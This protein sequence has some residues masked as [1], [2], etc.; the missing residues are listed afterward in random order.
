MTTNHNIYELTFPIR[1]KVKRN[2]RWDR[3]IKHRLYH[4]THRHFREVCLTGLVVTTL[5][6]SLMVPHEKARGSVEEISV[7]DDLMPGESRVGGDDPMVDRTKLGD[8]TM[9]IDLHYLRRNG[10]PSRIGAPYGA[11]VGIRMNKDRPT[12][13]P[14]ETTVNWAK[15]LDHL[16]QMK[17]ARSSVSGATQTWAHRVTEHYAHEERD[18]KS[19]GKF[20]KEVDGIAKTTHA[21]IDYD[22]ICNTLHINQCQDYKDTMSR[23]HGQNIVAYSLSEVMPSHNGAEN[24]IMLDTILRNAGE[25]YLDS[26]PSLGD[27]LLSKGAY[28]FTSFAVRRDESGMLGG[29]TFVDGFAGKHLPGSVIHLSTRDAHKAAFEFVA[30]N[31][32]NIFRGMDAQDAN[33]LAHVCTMDGITEIIATSHHMPAP[34]WL[35]AKKWAHDGCK[36]SLINHLGPQL[37]EYAEKTEANFNAI[38]HYQKG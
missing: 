5:G 8:Y 4:F 34:A 36:D 23:I 22:A 27:S 19:I 18:T 9:K 1:Q 38:K 16:W 31:F 29:A 6:V 17:L 26:I 7:S 3:E 33:R 28:Q 32:A 2:R 35:S 15:T 30:Y 21:S 20:I 14:D 11:L 37:R 10:N 25:N 13:I 12:F 24:Y